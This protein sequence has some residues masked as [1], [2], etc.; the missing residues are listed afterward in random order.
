[1]QRSS[2]APNVRSISNDRTPWKR[3]EASLA[4]ASIAGVVEAI[5]ASWIVAIAM[6]DLLVL[7]RDNAVGSAIA[8]DVA[9]ARVGLVVSEALGALA[10]S[11]AA[12]ALLLR[13]EHRA[14]A[15]ETVPFWT[16]V[17]A[18]VRIVGGA[19]VF[20]AGWKLGWSILLESRA[21]WLLAVLAAMQ[22][23]A[24]VVGSFRPISIGGRSSPSTPARAS[25]KQSA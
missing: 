10:V 21:P 13:M 9:L 23:A 11:V 20:G 15:R 12:G 4:A 5:V 7:I 22:L 14:A 3:N 18:V 19:I 1:M 17:V 8:V 6:R 2:L 25:G 24:L 16:R